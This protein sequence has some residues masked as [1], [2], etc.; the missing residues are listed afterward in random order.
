MWAAQEVR[1]PPVGRDLLFWGSTC[2]DLEAL[3]EIWLI[4][5]PCG[6]RQKAWTSLSPGECG[7]GN[8]L[9]TPNS[10]FSGSVVSIGS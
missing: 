9:E 10:A 6:G 3:M 4:G 7:R 8:A 1:C 5:A 2:G